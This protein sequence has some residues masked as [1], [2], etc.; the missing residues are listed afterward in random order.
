MKTS[1]PLIVTAQILEQD[2]Q[3]FDTLRKQH[4]PADRNF[5]RAHVTL[6]HRLPGEY[7]GEVQHRLT[8]VASEHSAIRAEIDGLRHLG[9]GVAFTISSPQLQQ[10]HAS[11]KLLFRPWLGGQDMQ[12]WQPHI[13]VQN[14]VAKPAA[15]ALY[16]DLDQ[17]FQKSSICVTGLDLWRYLGG[18]WQHCLSIPFTVS[19]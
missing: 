8:Q 17:S 3:A 9:A 19:P 14:K 1:E 6:F 4:F 11:L 18:P 2:L 15:D 13:T 12:K 10:V 5:L 7:L 16:K